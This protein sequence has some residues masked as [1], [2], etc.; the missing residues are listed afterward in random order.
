VNQFE[1]P[2]LRIIDEGEESKMGTLFGCRSVDRPSMQEAGTL[3]RFA[4]ETCS[5]FLSRSKVIL[6]LLFDHPLEPLYSRLEDA[7]KYFFDNFA[8]KTRDRVQEVFPKTRGL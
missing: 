8:R 1:L 3:S 4:S 7:R 6:L 5:Y 2:A